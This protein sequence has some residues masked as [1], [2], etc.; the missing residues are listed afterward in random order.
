M[1]AHEG[2]P[3]RVFAGLKLRQKAPRKHLD[4]VGRLLWRRLQEIPKL[5]LP[6]IQEYPLPEVI[7]AWQ[8]AGNA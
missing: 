1:R 7:A 5:G 2:L 3:V 6:T 4:L 8:A